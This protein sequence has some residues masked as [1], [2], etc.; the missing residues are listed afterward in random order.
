[1]NKLG[2]FMLTKVYSAMKEKWIHYKIQKINTTKNNSKK[3]T[4]SQLPE[5]C[6]FLENSKWE[7]MTY[8][9]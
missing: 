2:Y 7:C 6:S 8:M 1:M 5:S 9:E 4:R 3:P